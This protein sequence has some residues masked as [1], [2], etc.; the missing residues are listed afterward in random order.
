MRKRRS[1]SEGL[2]NTQTLLVHAWSQLGQ[3]L[4]SVDGEPNCPRATTD[5]S[6]QSLWPILVKE[7]G[8]VHVLIPSPGKMLEAG[9]G[10]GPHCAL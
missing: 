10:M 9:S 1:E 8:Q 2:L 3:A 7:Y 5:L 4:D 6:E